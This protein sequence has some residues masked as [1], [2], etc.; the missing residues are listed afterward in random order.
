MYGMG[1]EMQG[2]RVKMEKYREWD[3]EWGGNHGGN[4]GNEGNSRKWF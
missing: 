1:E 3:W 4:E 2:I